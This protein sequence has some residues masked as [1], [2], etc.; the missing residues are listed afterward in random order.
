MLGE[1]LLGQLER[2]RIDLL[3]DLLYV[4]ERGGADVRVAQS[5][6]VRVVVRARQVVHVRL[7]DVCAERLP[8]RLEVR[9]DGAVVGA[10]DVLLV[11]EPS[12]SA[13]PAGDLLHMD[14]PDLLHGRVELRLVPRRVGVEDPV[15]L[16]L[17][18]LQRARS[19]TVRGER[20]R[21]RDESLDGFCAA[22]RHR[23]GWQG[24]PE[25]PH[26]FGHVRVG[27][28]FLPVDDY[29][30]LAARHRLEV[31]G[32]ELHDLDGSGAIEERK[33]AVDRVQA[34][35]SRNAHCERASDHAAEQLGD[36]RVVLR[37]PE[38]HEHL[39][40]RAVPARRDRVLRD[41]YPDGRVVLNALRFDPVHLP[42]A[43]PLRGVVAEDV[44]HRVSPQVRVLVEDGVERDTDVVW[45]WRVW[46]LK[47]EQ[48]VD[49]LDQ[50]LRLRVR[51]PPVG[52]FGELAGRP[53]YEDRIERA[54]LVWDVEGERVLH[55][56]RLL[57]ALRVDEH[58]LER[59]A[60]VGGLRLTHRCLEPFNGGR[61]AP[62]DRDRGAPLRAVHEAPDDRRL[63]AAVLSVEPA[64]RLVKDDVQ[65]R[66]WRAP[67]AAIV[68][69]A[70]GDHRSRKDGYGSRSYRGA[71]LG[72][73]RVRFRARPRVRCRCTRWPSVD[74]LGDAG[75]HDRRPTPYLRWT[76]GV[77]PGVFNA[78]I[79]EAL[80]Y[81]KGLHDALSEIHKRALEGD[82]VK[83]DVAAT[84]VDRHLHTPFAY[85]RLHEQLRGS[86]IK[87]IERYIDTH[88]KDLDKLEHSEKAIRVHVA[89]GITV[90]GRIDLVRRLDTDELAIVDFKSTERAQ[91]EDVTRDQ[92]H[93]YA[94]G[95]QELTGESADVIEVLN[96]DEKG[97]TTRESVDERLLGAVRDKIRGA[98]ASL[99]ANDLPR[100][101]H[102]DGHT[103]GTCD[104]V[105][106]CRTRPAA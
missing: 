80:G 35:V 24:R 62:H 40:A 17:R 75:E 71:V 10:L 97:K 67:A 69:F 55:E 23:L 58:R 6:V 65:G 25:V 59:L 52:R 45:A 9:P 73:R 92:L 77:G 56:A 46:R 2:L 104:L 72:E 63:V 95:Y 43:E 21:E 85:E 18:L 82:I 13:E 74:D 100:L 37:R 105:G 41:E 57:H 70:Y 48:G 4:G 94:V 79:H 81:G 5:V 53:A 42:R 39:G 8:G 15:H 96:L 61:D 93:V 86:A 78:P 28:Q 36:V 22:L 49:R 12:R 68:V 60:V 38:G 19:D 54:S 88:R 11:R 101:P 26:G 30:L 66:R 89:P 91:A 27:Q 7:G 47:Y 76:G 84:L 99:R 34:L 44:A 31:S 98:G 16:G 64:M 1:Q 106:L 83:R 33:N 87:S 32:E 20:L 102:W 29:L 103:C 14:V 51:R 90:D 3:A 50:I